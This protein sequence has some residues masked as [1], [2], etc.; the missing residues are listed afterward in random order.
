[1]PIVKSD[2]ITLNY[3]VTGQGPPLLLIGGLGMPMQGWGL[4][5]KAFSRHFKL[6]RMDNRGCGR[7]SLPDKPFSIQE[8]SGDVIDVLDHLDLEFVHVLGV[9]M[10]GFIA[11]ELAAS[12]PERVKSLVLAHTAPRTPDLA[13]QRMTLWQLM[14]KEP[15]SDAILAREQLLWIFPEKIMENDKTMK[16]VMENLILGMKAQSPEGFKSQADACATFD[17]RDRLQQIPQPVL[18]ISSEDDISIPLS[19][20]MK[21]KRLPN[22]RKVKIFPSAGHISHLIHA[23][24][25]NREV[26]DFLQS[27]TFDVS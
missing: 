2:P 26:I 10:G 7:S 17:I 15:V 21:L 9:S 1:M 24:A 18:I 6:I 16:I 5:M 25:F 27:I 4:Q 12:V 14:R 11:M 23:E 8:M 13:R 20:T 3:H 22:V 19:H